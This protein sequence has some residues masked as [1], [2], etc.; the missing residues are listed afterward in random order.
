MGLIPQTFNNL[1]IGRQIT[2]TVGTITET[3]VV[4]GLQRSSSPGW[5]SI[6][7]VNWTRPDKQEFMEELALSTIQSYYSDSDLYMDEP[8]VVDEIRLLQKVCQPFGNHNLVACVTV[9][10]CIMPCLG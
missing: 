6:Y 9:P 2:R 7:S 4:H 10:A 3:G 8:Y 1:P 5:L